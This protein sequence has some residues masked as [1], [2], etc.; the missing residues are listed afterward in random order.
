VNIQYK[1][2]I[3]SAGKGLR[4]G[5]LTKSL[6]KALLPI[7]QKAIISHIIEKFP[8]DIEIVIAVGYQGEKIRE[9]LA[10]AHRD[11][12]ITIVDV[13]NFDGPGSGPGLSLLSCKESLQCPFIIYASDTMISEK[14]LPVPSKNWMG[15]ARISKNVESFCTVSIEN[16][17]ISKIVDKKKCDNKLAFIGVSGIRDYRVFWKSLESD[18][19]LI[20]GEHQISNGL[21]SLIDLKYYPEKFTWRDTGTEKNYFKTRSF[22]ENDEDFNFDKINEFT[23][24]VNKRVIKYFANQEHIRK[25]KE[26]SES[27]SGLCP[28][29][30]IV[31]R[32]FFSYTMI[33]G[34]TLY[35]VV[36]PK[37]THNFLSWLEKNLW[38]ERKYVSNERFTQACR[39]FYKKKTYDR[40]SLFYKK[41][42]N[43]KDSKILVNGIDLP[44]IESLLDN[45]E[46]EELYKGIQ[47]NFHGDLQFDNVLKTGWG[48]EEINSFKLLDWRQDFGG[49]VECGDLYYDLGKLYGGLTLPYSLIKKNKF[50][51]NEDFEKGSQYDF[52]TSH[53]IG[54]SRA[55]FERFVKASPYSFR[56]VKTIRGLIFLNMSPLHEAPFDKM[57]YQMSRYYLSQ[58]VN[59]DK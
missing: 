10:H 55:V 25:R 26:R 53:N 37:I 34:E 33:K 36:S 19:T 27:L 13:K 4:L 12:N 7:N 2:C 43:F 44:R 52:E 21:S 8:T 9:Y 1:V 22:Y 18:T 28:D 30:D 46:W 6:N 15:V 59:E 49:L 20:D 23:Y 45:I 41:Y 24:F 32:W 50:F 56:K 35:N 40:L 11:R 3:L 16:G 48:S 57:L 38:K 39:D 14:S 42:P 54:E 31:T 29:L 58:A 51:Y 5:S 47:S 17:L